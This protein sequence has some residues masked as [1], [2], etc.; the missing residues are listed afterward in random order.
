MSTLL[1]G[2]SHRSLPVLWP[3]NNGTADEDV[4]VI[5]ERAAQGYRGFMFKMG[6][7]P[8]ASEIDR[9][10]AIET[11]Y[12]SRLKFVADANQGW[13]RDQAS[14]FLDGVKGSRLVF[15]EQPL[16]GS[17][18]EGMAALARDTAL[19]LSVDESLIG[20]QVAGEIARR[21]A[22]SVFSIKSSKNGGPLRAQRIPRLP[23]P[24][25]SNAI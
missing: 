5:D 7:S 12:G 6:T 25:V 11:R 1:G 16:V 8:I 22:A 3:L 18:I 13:S 20:L 19:P 21:S 24:S 17:D 4:R 14:E 10:A 15:V 23:R 9:V 2:A